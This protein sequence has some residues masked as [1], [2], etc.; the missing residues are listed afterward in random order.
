MRHIQSPT[1]EAIAL[2]TLFDSSYAL[3]SF[4]SGWLEHKLFPTLL[5]PDVVACIPSALYTFYFT[6]FWCDSPT[7]VQSSPKPNSPEKPSVDPGSYHN[8]VFPLSSSLW[9]NVGNF[10]LPEIPPVSPLFSQASGFGPGFPFALR[11]GKLAWTTVVLPSCFLCSGVP[12]LSCCQLFESYYSA[13][14]VHICS[15]LRREDRASPCQHIMA[16][17]GSLSEAARCYTAVQNLGLVQTSAFSTSISGMLGGCWRKS[18]KC[19]QWWHYIFMAL[20]FSCLLSTISHY[21]Y[22]RCLPTS[23]SPQPQHLESFSKQINLF[24]MLQRRFKGILMEIPQISHH[25][26]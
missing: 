4:H 13:Y 24:H 15:C 10:G 3:R 25:Y 1:T 11:P 9:S 19:E 22:F 20:N 18:H 16:R 21:S 5:T 26:A 8:A 12:V 7:R 2:W 14:S 17:S 23:S 6:S